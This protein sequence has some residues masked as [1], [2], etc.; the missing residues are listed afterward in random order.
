[1]NYI[2]TFLL[3]ITENEEDAFFIMLGLFENTYFSEFFLNNLAKLKEF[4]YVFE[5]LIN[6]YLPELSTFFKVKYYY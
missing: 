5:R 6:I 4:F 2:A 3:H 1:M